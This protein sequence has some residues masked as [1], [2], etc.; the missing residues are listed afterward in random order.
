MVEIHGYS[1]LID[2]ESFYRWEREAIGTTAK[3]LE[4]DEGRLG[5]RFALLA[6]VYQLCCLFTDEFYRQMREVENPA[7][8]VP[9]QGDEGCG[10]SILPQRRNG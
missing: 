8:L 9:F 5:C 3:G 7:P 2:C 1:D 4:L 10:I 6:D